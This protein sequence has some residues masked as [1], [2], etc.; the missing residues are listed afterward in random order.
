MSAQSILKKPTV[1][2]ALPESFWIWLLVQNLMVNNEVIYRSGFS[3][4][5]APLVVF[6][7]SDKLLV[8]E[9]RWITRTAA[10]LVVDCRQ[11]RYLRCASP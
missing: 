6:T 2:K 9:A 8:A 11:R 1:E 4:S 5:F 3:D 7:E 10:Q